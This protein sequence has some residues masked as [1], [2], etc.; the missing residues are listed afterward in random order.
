MAVQDRPRHVLPKNEQQEQLKWSI[1]QIR[2]RKFVDVFFF[3]FFTKNLKAM[4]LLLWLTTNNASFCFYVNI[5]E[6]TM[7][8]SK[9]IKY[10][11]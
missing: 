2:Y 11:S 5:K 4:F 8:D 10:L 1:W 3:A 7:V 9:V 6:E